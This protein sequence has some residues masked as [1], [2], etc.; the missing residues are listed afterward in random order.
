[1]SLNRFPF[2]TAALAAAIIATPLT[3]AAAR[4]YHEPT[5]G[6]F[7]EHGEVAPSREASVELQTG[8]PIAGQLGTDVGGGIR[9]GLPKAELMIN[10]G[11][12]DYDQNELML[13]WGMTRPSGNSG[14]NWALLGGISQMNYEVNRFGADAEVDQ[15]NLKAGVALTIRADAGIFTIQPVLVY[16]DGEV[17][18]SDGDKSE[19]I[20]DTFLELGLGGY[21][22]LADTE[23]GKFSIG[24]EAI[25]T[26]QDNQY[27]ADD[28]DDADKDNTF[29][30]GVKWA[31]SERV[32]LD[33]V[34]LVHTNDELLGIPGLVRLNVAF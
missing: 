21:L 23:A 26:T 4:N 16:A 2:K 29:A 34:P 19:L 5:R 6:F 30:L 9:L 33:I 12:G 22:G 8:R 24:V 3:E 14:T 20:D 28:D 10:S 31:Y 13:K 27:G 25:I 18:D 11:L 1:M 15:L 32:H 17:E 7:I